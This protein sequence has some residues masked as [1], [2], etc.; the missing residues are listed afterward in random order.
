MRGFS[1]LTEGDTNRL[2]PM[3]LNCLDALAVEI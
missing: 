1:T 2:Y 3:H